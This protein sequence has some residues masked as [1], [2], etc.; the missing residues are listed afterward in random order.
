[1]RLRTRPTHADVEALHDVVHPPVEPDLSALVRAELERQRA[2]E[3]TRRRQAE[4][5]RFRGGP[6]WACGCRHSIEMDE[7]GVR[8]AAWYSRPRGVEDTWCTEWRGAGG[9]DDEL[10]DKVA[11]ILR[12]EGLAGLQ[13]VR[14]SG[15]RWE[16][17][18]AVELGVV[19]WADSGHP[20][21]GQRWGHLAPVAERLAAAPA[22]D[23]GTTLADLLNGQADVKRSHAVDQL[24]RRRDEL[25][26]TIENQPPDAAR[27]RMLGPHRASRREEAEVELEGVERELRFL[28][29][30]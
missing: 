11:F 10:L 24:L 14:R 8:T 29:A 30:S 13:H 1:M 16:P 28:G 23:G 6:C 19:A 2:E 17:G 7:D 20:T 25:R 22:D 4:N 26:V 21:T 9:T 3:Q 27:L 12:A 5:E 15:F 18:M